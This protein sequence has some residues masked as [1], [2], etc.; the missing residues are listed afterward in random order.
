MPGAVD[1]TEATVVR[2][3]FDYALGRN[4]LLLGVKAIVSQLNEAGERF[5]GKLFHISNV[6]RILTSPTCA[7]TH[8]FNRRTAR[9]G[10]LKPKEEWV[11]TPVPALICQEAFEL[12]Q[13]SL[14]GRNPR[15]T[16]PRVVNGPTLL[17]RLAICAHCG[18]GMT[19]RTG[20]SGQ[21]RYYACAGAAQKGKT[22]CPG[23][24][25]SMPALDAAVT[26]TL[27]DRLFTPSRLTRILN[28]VID[29]STAAEA[30]RQ[31]RLATARRAH[32]EAG[33]RVTRLLQPVE[34]GAMEIDDPLFRERLTAAKD[35]RREAKEELDLAHGATV[36]GNPSIK[37]VKIERL[38]E[39]MNTTMRHADLAS[40]KAYLRLFVGRIIITDNEIRVSG[41]TAAI[42]RSAV[43]EG[44]L[45][46]AAMGP[47]FV[48]D[49]YTVRDSSSCYRPE[50]TAHG[51]R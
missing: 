34:A 30:A 13:A 8:I 44:Q 11:H 22:K 47:S 27:A 17:T 36:T 1:E 20:K 28:A 24:A 23:R 46:A 6:Y 7:G 49:W 29:H 40:R 14:A 48:P 43:H 42:E 50:M 18:S 33:G 31:Q 4:G 12:V 41:P 15:R 45:T 5:H 26:T 10:Q 32:A 51:V 2:R 37:P 25:V 16:P 9:T 21:Y 39:A 3:I 38:V 35:A 19:M